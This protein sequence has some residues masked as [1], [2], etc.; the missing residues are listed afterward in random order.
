MR[1]VDPIRRGLRRIFKRPL[2]KILRVRTVDPIRRGLRQIGSAITS[3]IFGSVRTVDPIRR[4][5]RRSSQF[6]Y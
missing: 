1:T 6:C 4:G 2:W 5:L 3:A